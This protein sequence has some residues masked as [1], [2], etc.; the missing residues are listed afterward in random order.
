M[1]SAAA[2]TMAFNSLTLNELAHSLSSRSKYRNVFGGQSLSP[3]PHL[4]RAI[5]GMA[6]L[7]ALVSI[8]VNLGALPTKGLT[9]PLISYGRSSLIVTMMAL[10]MLLRI[11]HE[12][13]VDAADQI[14]T[15]LRYNPDLAQARTAIARQEVG[16]RVARVRDEGLEVEDLNVRVEMDK[17]KSK[18]A[19]EQANRKFVQRFAWI[20]AELERQGEAIEE[21]GL[22]R[23]ESLWRQAKL[24]LT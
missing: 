12:L 16:V 3:N 23:L 10:G 24:Q 8:G 13:T 7:Q 4:L 14:A 6:G 11:H 2:S 1:A 22:E 19:L 9:L 20:E 21:A 17:A 15:A 5:G 18:V